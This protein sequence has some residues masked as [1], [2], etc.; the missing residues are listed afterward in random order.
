MSAVTRLVC[1][2]HENELTIAPS[3]A[4]GK[5]RGFHLIRAIV[6]HERTDDRPSPATGHPPRRTPK[7]R[8]FRHRVRGQARSSRETPESRPITR[9]PVGPRT[10]KHLFV[11]NESV[12]F[13][14]VC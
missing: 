4:R 1:L 12:I 9:H 11:G 13:A 3:P 2:Q 10:K 7:P 8:L 5:P 6:T 14:R